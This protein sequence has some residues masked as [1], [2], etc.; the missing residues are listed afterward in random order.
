MNRASRLRA[1]TITLLLTLLT[2]PIAR[3]QVVDNTS[4]GTIVFEKTDGDILGEALERLGLTRADLGYRP[5]SS[6]TRYPLPTQIPYINTAFSD[7][8]ARPQVIPRYIHGMADP[9]RKYLAPT[10]LATEDDALYQLAY[11]LGVEKFAGGFRNYSANCLPAPATD[12][13]LFDAIARIRYDFGQGPRQGSFGDR[14]QEDDT[15]ELA[16]RDQIAALAPEVRSIV[17]GLIL[18]LA[19]AARWTDLSFRRAELDLLA[20]V[21]AIV[22]IPNSETYLPELDDLA[23]LWDRQSLCY[24]ALKAAQALDT[25]RLALLNLDR[26]LL[27]GE[28]ILL[29]TRTPIGRIVVSGTDGEEYDVTECLLWL[30]LGGDDHY[31]GSPAGSRAGEL[32]VSVLLEMDGRDTYT[33][34]DGALGAGLL[35]LGLLVDV[36]GDDRYESTT[37]GQGYGQFGFGLLADLAGD[38]EWTMASCGQGAGCFGM[39]I[40]LDA[41]GNDRYYLFGEGQGFGGVGGVGTLASWGGNDRY[42]AEP[43]AA[44]AGRA[45][46]HSDHLVAANAAQGCGMGRRGDG[47]DGHSWAGG[48]GALIE[49]HGR[50]E[51]RSGNWS[52]GTGFWY[53]IGLLY[54]GDG[55]DTFESVYFTQ[56]SGAHFCIGSI[57]DEGGNDSHRLFENAGAGIAFGWD[58]TNAL[59]IDTEGDDIYEAKIISLGLS[60]IRS[61]ALLIDLKGD[62]IYRLDAGQL[63]FGA[64]DMQERYGEAPATAPYYGESLSIGLLLDGGGGDRYELRDPDT[65]SFSPDTLLSD[66][67]WRLR[68]APDSPDAGF[69]NYGAFW[70]VELKSLPELEP[71][72]H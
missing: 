22:D 13:P 10:R 23:L 67:R 4:I 53:G 33:G 30:D 43:Y 2:C 57:L 48:L 58:Y 44:K 66:N 32:P 36:A 60:E 37:R 49:I 69:D 54:E 18:N 59:L 27:R 11:Y 14:Y 61:N 20:R 31:G 56:A 55:D 34:R 38:D 62:D 9:V 71:F 24:G 26:K 15:E 19:D 16:L 64:A 68:P 41:A 25:A 35:G 63:G 51:Y 46:Y 47:S 52:L 28:G 29:D 12:S 39:G 21:E 42:V 17:A 5:L 1:I 65:N 72:L 70:D 8:F 40:H 6:W 50:D 3:A 7:L 45:D